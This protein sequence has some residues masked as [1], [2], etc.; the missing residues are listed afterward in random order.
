M[1]SILKDADRAEI[2]R[3]IGS[4]TS[5]S[6]PRWGGMPVRHL[7]RHVAPVPHTDHHLRQFGA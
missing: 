1:G 5:A 7:I 3:R 4:V 6:V 2:C